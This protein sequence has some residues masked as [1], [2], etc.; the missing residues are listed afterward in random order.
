MARVC[1]RRGIVDELVSLSQRK[2]R[3][4]C[5]TCASPQRR[6]CCGVSVAKVFIDMC[7]SPSKLAHQQETRAKKATVLLPFVVLMPSCM[8]WA[9]IAR[10]YP[11]QRQVRDEAHRFAVAYHRKLRGKD[12]FLPAGRAGGG[13]DGDREGQRGFEAIA[14]ALQLLYTHAC[15]FQVVVVVLLLCA[16]HG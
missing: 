10:Y 12:L 14:G 2:L 16:K 9:R 5:A 11:R 4:I 15:T 13:V 8:R 3:S 6:S 7:V 1:V